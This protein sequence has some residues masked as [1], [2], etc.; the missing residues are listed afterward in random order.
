MGLIVS[1]ILALI[2]NEGVR[3]EV[4]GLIF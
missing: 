2:I 3:K 4:L 1:L